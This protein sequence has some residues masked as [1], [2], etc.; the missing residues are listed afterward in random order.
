MLFR[1]DEV[2]GINGLEYW[3]LETF[4]LMPVAGPVSL[5]TATSLSAAAAML[6][7]GTPYQ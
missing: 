5:I 2:N 3:I 4:E 7:T 6:A 1:L